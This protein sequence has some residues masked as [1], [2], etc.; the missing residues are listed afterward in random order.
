VYLADAMPEGLLNR[1]ATLKE[2]RI[3]PR[4]DPYFADS[5]WVLEKCQRRKFA[6][7]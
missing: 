6:S 7:D 3:K 4:T 2:L 1:L 5:A